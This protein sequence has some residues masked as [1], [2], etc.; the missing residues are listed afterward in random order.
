MLRNAQATVQ[1]NASEI[2]ETVEKIKEVFPSLPISDEAK[3][4]LETD[5]QTL[6][7]QLLSTRPKLGI[8]KAC[9]ASMRSILQEATAHTAAILLA[10]E[11]ASHLEK[12][13]R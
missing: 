1:F 3:E 8:V 13:S 12:I 11:I 5:I 6:E 9:L 4:E 2:R 7:P 10:H